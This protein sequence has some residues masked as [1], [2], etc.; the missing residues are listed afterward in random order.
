MTKVCPF[1]V[2]TCN[3]TLR[4]QSITFLSH[5]FYDQLRDLLLL[6]L[7]LFLLSGLVFRLT[8]CFSCVRI[9][10]LSLH[11]I[12]GQKLTG[13]NLIFCISMAMNF[14]FVFSPF[15]RW[16]FFY[17]SSL[18]FNH[19]DDRLFILC[20]FA[21]SLSPWFVAFS[22][23]MISR[24]KTK[25]ITNYVFHLIKIVFE[26][27]FKFIVSPLSIPNSIRFDYCFA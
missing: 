21:S 6:L 7:F 26:F 11:V 1:K 13:E 3:Y 20:V 10:L 8:F 2:F 23:W 25:S 12:F 24:P 4:V 15:D 16:F 18:N 14:C 19:F 5:L 22:M 17:L 27:L 9:M